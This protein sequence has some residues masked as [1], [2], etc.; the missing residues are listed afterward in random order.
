MRVLVVDDSTLFRK[1]VRDVL[2]TIP[3]VEVVGVATN[4][5]LA[6]EKIEQLQP[7]LLTLDI[8][9]PELDGLGVLRHLKDQPSAPGAIMLSALTEKGAKLT[10]EA[11]ALGA[12]DFI[13]KPNGKTIADNTKQ[14]YTD[15]LPRVS[16]FRTSR[17]VSAQQPTPVATHENNFPANAGQPKVCLIGISTGGPAALAKLL[18]SISADYPLPIIIVQHMPAVFTRKLAESLNEHCKLNVH[19]I[20]DGMTIDAGNVYIAPGG[21][22]TQVV[23]GFPH[24]TLKVTDDPPENHCKPSVDYL[25][26]HAAQVYRGKMLAIIMT[27][28][29]NDGTESCRQLRSLGATVVA[30][31]EASSVV[32]GMPRSIVESGLASAVCPLDGIANKMNELTR[33]Q[34]LCR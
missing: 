22:Q 33:G 27:G 13:L 6:L 9:M 28:M 15:L 7:D 1:V 10:N 4:G 21:K 17:R 8:E 24:A 19:E 2:A 34:L 18:P 23:A 25:F 29:G 3:G 31:D 16:A 20:E 26:R 5:K 11:L 12:F 32:Y 14:L 30:Q